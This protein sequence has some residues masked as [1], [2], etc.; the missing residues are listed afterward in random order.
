MPILMQMGHLFAV[1]LDATSV[2]I[3]K[4]TPENRQRFERQ[5]QETLYIPGMTNEQMNEFGNVIR[6]VFDLKQVTVQNNLGTIVLRAPSSALTA[7]NLT[8]EDLINGGNQ[9]VFD[10]KLYAVDKTH[11]TDIGVQ[12]PQQIGIW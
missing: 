5:I 2:L 11:A 10:L 12:P 1:P 9:V 6:N 3:A 8:V 4:D 7:I